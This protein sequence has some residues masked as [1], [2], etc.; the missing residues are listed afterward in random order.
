MYD[1]VIVGGGAA[2]LSAA[3]VLGRARRKVLVIDAGEP[4]NA[5]AEHSHSFFT[6]DGATPGELLR[7]GREQAAGYGIEIRAGRVA[8]VA[9]EDG[10]FGVA[11]EGGGREPARRV[12]IAAGV[13][14]ELPK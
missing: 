13:V 9:R 12:L 14:D 8:E 6:R 2:G 3:L 10:G 7:I 4:R 11:V 1:A 5:P